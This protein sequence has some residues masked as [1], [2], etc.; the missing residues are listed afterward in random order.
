MTVQPADLNLLRSN[1]V[2]RIHPSKFWAATRSMSD[3]EKEVL[4]Q[5]IARLAE[6]GD[7]AGLQHFDFISL[8]ERPEIAAA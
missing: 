6:V 2:V 8:T 7:F 5:A 1:T 3:Q 4:L